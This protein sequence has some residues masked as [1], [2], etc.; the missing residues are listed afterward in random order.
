MSVDDNGG[1]LPLINGP[2][3]PPPPP[4][5][6]T[7][8]HKCTNADSRWDWQKF[9][10]AKCLR[11]NSEKSWNLRETNLNSSKSVNIGETNW[12][13]KLKRGENKFWTA[14]LSTAS[15]LLLSG[16]QSVRDRSFE[17]TKHTFSSKRRGFETMKHTLYFRER[18]FETMKHTFSYRRR[19]FEI[20]K[21][22]FYFRDRGFE[23]TK[24]TF[25][26]RRRGFETIKQTL[27]FKKM[28]YNKFG[29]LLLTRQ[30]YK[31][32]FREGAINETN[33]KLGK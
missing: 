16:W 27:C 5:T 26:F 28:K 8:T 3:L 31:K 24:H 20:M 25:S 18:C 7:H 29:K 14:V 33:R 2:T 6:H 30:W 21:H 4:P 10:G 22:T 1:L 13:D 15:L 11:R 23:T 32:I 9:L 12:K 17:T 19:V